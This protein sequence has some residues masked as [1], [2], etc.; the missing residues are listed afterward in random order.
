MWKHF[1]DEIIVTKVKNCCLE[2]QEDLELGLVAV[3]DVAIA[4]TECELVAMVLIK[5]DLNWML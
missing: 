3:D 5:E 2:G 4:A 1:A